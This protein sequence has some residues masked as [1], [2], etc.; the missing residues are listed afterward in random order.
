MASPLPM[1]SS[2]MTSPG[3]FGLLRR[4]GRPVAVRASGPQGSHATS[5]LFCLGQPDGASGGQC[6]CTRPRARSVAGRT[7]GQRGIGRVRG[8]WGASVD[9]GRQGRD[10]GALLCALWLPAHRARVPDPLS[11]GIGRLSG[12]CLGA[13]RGR[14]H[15]CQPQVLRWS[16]KEVHG[17]LVLLGHFLLLA[18]AFLSFEPF[19]S[20]LDRCLYIRGLLDLRADSGY[21][22]L[23]VGV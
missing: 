18:F 4:R 20:V 11:P 10:R 14:T 2:T 3:V 9:R 21:L 19:M 17:P 8:V 6:R 22:N 16:A 13:C 23:V 5:P 1:S 15:R 12:Q 7:C